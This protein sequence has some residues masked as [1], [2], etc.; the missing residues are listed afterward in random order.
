MGRQF[1]LK[2]MRNIGIMAHI[3]AGKTTT[4]ERI[5]FHAGKIHKIGETHDGASQMDWMEQEK[6]RGI[7]ITS[8]ATTVFWK[9]NKI[10]I[11]DTPGHVDFTVE[12][13]RSLRVLDGAIA[14]IDAQAGVEPQT[15][16]VW[17]QATEYKVPRIIFVNKM[18]KIGADF[19]YAVRDL[20]QKLGIK[21]AAIQWPI[22]QENEFKG[23]VDLIEMT[24]F[25]YDGSPDEKGKFVEIPD[26]LKEIVNIK[27][28]EL[29]EIL[30]DFDDDL[31]NLFL[32]NKPINPVILK[33]VIRNA[34]LNINFFP[35]LC[36]SSF[37]N[38][39]VLKILDS[40]I[41]FLPSPI[42]VAPILGFD[43]N[44]KEI[45][46]N[47]SDEEP[48]VALAF[49]IMTDPF[50]GRLTFLRIYSGH[51]R[52]G[53]YIY[54]TSKKQVLKE[55]VSRLLQMH[56]NNRE[57]IEDVY[58]GDIVAV[59]GLK[60]TITGD[61]LTTENNFVILESMNFPDP[62]IEI[63]V[64][65]K[66]KNDRSK[67]TTALKKLAAEDPTFKFY[68]NE[69]TNQTIIAG[70]GE[71]HLDIII[72]RLKSEFSVEI[73]TNN[74]QVSYRETFIQKIETE[75][76]YISQTGGSGNYG[77]VKIIF[78]PNEEGKG[79]EFINKIVGGVI[80]QNFIETVR[81]CLDDISTQGVI[82]GY[83][84][85]DFKATLFDGSIH[86]VDS[87]DYAFQRATQNALS[88]TKDKGV[89]SILE[90]IM[91]LEV[92]TPNEYLGNVMGDL[93]PRR[94][95][96]EKQENKDNIVICIQSSVPLAQMFGYATALRSR[97]QGRANFNM[98][99]KK[100]ERVPKNI[101]EKI[102]QER[103]LMNIKKI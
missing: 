7:T 1:S 8:A 14:I 10:Q 79:F 84:L 74:P 17:R 90:P 48:F 99:F 24:A 63:A 45:V 64:E 44:Q 78:E 50:V 46:I 53:S 72:G 31:M 62:V 30:S 95:K 38:K 43:K 87:N 88:F 18:D 36:G 22:G 102:I 81:K 69:E 54:N 2:N 71:L 29:I 47:P 49:K 39:G 97:T 66:N 76:K 68:T 52:I 93:I 60:E 35:V 37:K 16:T 12:V 56:A 23:I 27:R 19:E 86:L 98:E 65:P 100:Y 92:T 5:L 20:K 57:E 41:D 13:S 51:L 80:P 75:G 3:D 21:V 11:I 25:E 15:E 61:T 73:T 6:K 96:I 34:T 101:Q 26:Y 42:E 59:I 103:S 40:I 82:A 67:I 28:N 70:M 32:Y 77:H 55:R 94:G 85:I 33:K 58:T 89:I 91:K 83:P 9:E 4:T